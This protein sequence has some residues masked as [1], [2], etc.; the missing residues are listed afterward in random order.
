MLAITATVLGIQTLELKSEY[1]EDPTRQRL[2]RGRTYRTATNVLW[3]LTAAAAA[4]STVLFVFTDF[5]GS[6]EE[7]GKLVT[8][9]GL[10]LRGALVR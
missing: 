1:D 3:G 2:D 9:L 8:T 5:R 7:G 4:G 10:A 6:P